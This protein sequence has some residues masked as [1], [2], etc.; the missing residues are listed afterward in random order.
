[1]AILNGIDFDVEERNEYL[2]VCSLIRKEEKYDMDLL[3]EE[4]FSILKDNE[5]FILSVTDKGFGKEAL[6]LNIEKQIEGVLGL[7][8][9]N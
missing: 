1:M 3:S 9:C 7:R 6:L 5:E 8:I 2:R 4:K